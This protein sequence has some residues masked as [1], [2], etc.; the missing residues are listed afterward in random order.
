VTANS[1]TPGLATFNAADADDVRARLLT[2][3]ASPR[4]AEDLV[5]DR[6]YADVDAVLARSDE[7]LR[8]ADEDQIDAA[9]AGHPR[10]GERATAEHFDDESAARSAREQAGVGSA[11]AD[12]KRQLAAVNAAYEQRFGRIY[13]VAAAGLSAAELLAKARAR[14]GNEP[15]AELTVIRAELATITRTRL[16]DWLA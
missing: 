11:D 3:T 13:L 1:D 8:A 7:L 4:W 12:Q 5:A 10:I 9:L 6:P 14:L 2:L 16:L 15:E